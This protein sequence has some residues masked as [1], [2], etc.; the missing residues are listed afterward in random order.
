MRPAHRP[1][2]FLAANANK[3]NLDIRRRHDSRRSYAGSDATQGARKYCVSEIAREI[4]ACAASQTATRLKI[5]WI[6]GPNM[7]A[8]AGAFVGSR[9]E[10]CPRRLPMAVSYDRVPTKRHHRHW[11]INPRTQALEYRA[12]FEVAAVIWTIQHQGMQNLRCDTIAH[13]KFAC[14]ASRHAASRLDTFG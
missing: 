5:I 2:D 12:T 3:S 4:F 13:A 14:P 1:S 11:L 8:E 10:G 6:D 7:A 9:T